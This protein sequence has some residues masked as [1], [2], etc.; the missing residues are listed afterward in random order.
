MMDKKLAI[1]SVLV[2]NSYVRNEY[3]YNRLGLLKEKDFFEA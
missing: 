1:E 3:M 2:T